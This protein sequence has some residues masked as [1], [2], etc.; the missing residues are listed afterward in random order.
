MTEIKSV[1]DRNW[2]GRTGSYLLCRWAVWAMH[3][4]RQ[5]FTS[6]VG[7]FFLKESTET[8]HITAVAVMAYSLLPVLDS[9][10]LHSCFYFWTIIA[11]SFQ[12]SGQDVITGRCLTLL[13]PGTWLRCYRAEGSAFS[14]PVD[15]H[16]ILLTQAFRDD[17]K[18]HILLIK[19][20]ITPIRRAATDRMM[21]NIYLV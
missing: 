20:W 4:E 18:A 21:A 17:E 5:A 15:L 1:N 9:L 13:S 16:R 8:H 19:C 10:L 12:L 2:E 7:L 11:V 6:G 14:L 3:K